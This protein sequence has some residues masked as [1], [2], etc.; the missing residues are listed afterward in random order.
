MFKRGD[1]E[2]WICLFGLSFFP[3]AHI[4][5]GVLEF[6]QGFEKF[7]K[8]YWGMGRW[9]GWGR[10]GSREQGA[11][12][13]GGKVGKQGGWVGEMGRGAMDWEMDEEGIEG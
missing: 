7:R 9:G 2:Q 6:M 12:W 1:W 10:R 11:R 5:G 3:S 13:G 8:K 4:H